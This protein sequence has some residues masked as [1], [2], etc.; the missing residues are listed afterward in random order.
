MARVR[1]VMAA[2]ISCRIDVAGVA[3]DVDKDRF[4]AE[5][6]DDFGRRD[7]RERRCDDFVARPDADRHE[8]D[9]QRFRAARARDAVRR[10][11]VILETFFQLGH[12]GPEY[13]LA[14]LEHRAHARIDALT[15]RGV[16]GLQVDERRD[17]LHVRRTG[18]AGHALLRAA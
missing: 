11:G 14:V 18:I 12:F 13:E 8:R 17:R 1:E 16:L 9:Q 2:S 4:R 6:D 15:Q 5:Q 10:T 3:L 7:K